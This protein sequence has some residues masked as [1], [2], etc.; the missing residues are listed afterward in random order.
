MKRY[1]IVRVDKDWCPYYA[2]K[3]FIIPCSNFC[4][5][6]F[7]CKDCRYGDTKEQLI[8]KVAQAIFR[9]KLKM[10]KKVYGIIPNEN[11]T[12]QIYSQCYSVA[13]EIVEFLGVVE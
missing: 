6:R 13:K 9:R 10:Y 4:E 12:K 5:N 2:D 11:F 1:A 8:R 3:E 7:E